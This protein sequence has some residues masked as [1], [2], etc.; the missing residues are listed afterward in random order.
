MKEYKDSRFSMKIEDGILHA[1]FNEEFVDYS[2]VNDGIN[3]RIE[4]TQGTSY[5]M[6]SDFRKVKSGTRQARERMSAK[7]AGIGISAVAIL[8]E[9]GVQRVIYNFFHSIY[10]APAPARLFTNRDKALEWLQQYK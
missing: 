8:I 3:K 9:S 6:L 2:L 4:L 10:K 5:P 7:D 1:I